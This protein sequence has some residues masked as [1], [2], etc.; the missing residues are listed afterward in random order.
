MSNGI[1][2][3]DFLKVI[4]V[5][6]AGAGIAGCT[7]G[8]PE[9][10]L[11]YVVPPTDITPGV[12]T[13]Y[14]TVCGECAAG[15]SVWARTREGRVVKLEGNPNHP[16]S[17]G[18]LCQRGH[19]SL[20]GLYNPDRYAGPMLK[21]NGAFR[22]ATWDEAETML[23]QKLQAAGANVLLITGHA[24]PT[25]STLFDAFVAGVGGQR[26]EYE[27]LADAPLREAA[28]I[29]FGQDVVPHYDF[30]QA[31]TIVSF[32]ADFLETWLS[33][34]EYGRSFA[35]A[36]AVHDGN[37]KA[38]FVQIAPRLNLTG[39]NADEWLPIEPGA[40]AAVAL[41]MAGVIVGGGRGD[42]GPYAAMLSE[43]TPEAAARVSGISAQA[44]RDLAE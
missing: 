40:E 38:R 13:W 16:I 19:A 24:G 15:C 27:S 35:K 29:T 43:Y 18:A 21:E 36:A 1:K 14:T 41:A 39:L 3:R 12:A 9:K 30:A 33:P 31:Q 11:P 22:K 32:G 26:V 6:T 44:I 34:V 42:A 8:N 2:R 28:R 4:G 23:A 17:Q 37:Q 25:L 5:S 20:Q 10:L 7:N